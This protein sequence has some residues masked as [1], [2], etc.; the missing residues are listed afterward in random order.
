MKR[1]PLKD[2]KYAYP[3]IDALYFS[4]LVDEDLSKQAWDETEHLLQANREHLPEGYYYLNSRLHDSWVIGYDRTPTSFT[5]RLN[6]ISAH[7]FCEAVNALTG[8]NV[9]HR[10]TVCPVELVFTGVRQLRTCH[11]NRNGKILPLNTE[12]WL[13]EAKEFLCDDIRVLNKREIS[14]GILF[15]ARRVV[16]ES[17]R[18]LLEIDAERLQIVEMKRNAFSAICGAENGEF[19]ER[20]MEQRQKGMAF[21]YSAALDFLKSSC[22]SRNLETGQQAMQ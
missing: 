22:L 6:D 4:N 5:L 12:R 13:P 14:L 21:D 8:R 16:K 11:V 15:W 2:I 10:Q 17:K 18:L 1:S 9:T 3:K 7:C 19:F 20:F